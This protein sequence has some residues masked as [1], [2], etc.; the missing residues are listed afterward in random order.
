MSNSGESSGGARYHVPGMEGGARLNGHRDLP[1]REPASELREYLHVLRS[2]KLSILLVA[3]ASVAVALFYSAQQSAVYS[4]SARVLVNQIVLF[5]QVGAFKPNI[6]TER[7]VVDSEAVASLAAAQ[8][9]DHPDPAELL[10]GLSVGGVPETE[11][12]NIRYSHFDE[13][14]PQRRAQAFATAYLEFRRQQML[15]DQAGSVET[16]EAS[17]QDLNSKLDGVNSRIAATSDPLERTTLDSQANVLITRVAFLQQRL[18][19]VTSNEVSVGRVVS[20]A[21]PA[22]LTP[23]NHVWNGLVALFVGLVAGIGAAFLRE[24]L[25]DRLRGR[26]DLA[27]LA[28]APVLAAIPPVRR[29]RGRRP[30]LVTHMGPGSPMVESFRTL[31]A[32]LLFAAGQEKVKIVMVTSARPGEGKTTVTANLGIVLAAAGKRVVLVSADLRNPRLERFFGINI[33]TGQLEVLAGP[34][35]HLGVWEPIREPALVAGTAGRTPHD[36]LDRPEVPDIFATLGVGSAPASAE[37]R[38]RWPSPRRRQAG[39]SVEA[40]P[41]P[42]TGEEIWGSDQ[43]RE[44]L[45]RWRDSADIVLIDTPAI[46]AV[47]DA[48]SLAPMTDAVLLVAD[49]S[50]TSRESVRRA[51]EQLDQVGAF[52]VG[53]VL[54]RFHS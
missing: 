36:Q 13:R 20:A 52:V 1:T 54:N 10:G 51:R 16:L 22:T 28:D 14:E 35:N 18:S 53:A 9:D 29:W 44:R 23:A 19:D 39:R 2:R 32:N 27:A 45:Q 50:R 42:V 31:R 21:T 30:F 48:S 3:G 33:G 40:Q 6:D 47:A 46:L 5:S 34:V 26:D 37:D 17:I 12:L 41:L 24:R 38:G 25:D 15:Q 8:L 7:L 4:S 11:I 49:G 43:M